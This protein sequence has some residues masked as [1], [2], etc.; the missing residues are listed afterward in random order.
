LI[1]PD[2]GDDRAYHRPPRSASPRDHGKPIGSIKLGSLF[3]TP[4]TRGL[5]GQHIM[6]SEG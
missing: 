4:P 5:T 3:L 2:P 1:A 6:P